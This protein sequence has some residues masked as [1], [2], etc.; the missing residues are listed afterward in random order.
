MPEP[1][2][3]LIRF[4][5]FSSR[6][7]SQLRMTSLI[8]NDPRTTAYSA[9]WDCP[10][11]FIHTHNSREAEQGS[12]LYNDVVARNREAVWLYMPR[13]EGEYISHIWKRSRS[14]CR[15]LALLVVTNKGR[16]MMFGPQPHPSWRPCNWT[17]LHRS[18]GS[19][20]RIF[21]DVSPHGI[22]KLA[23]DSPEPISHGQS[24]IIPTPLSPYPESTS[25][26]DYFYTFAALENVVE[27]TPCEGK[28]AG[29]R[30]I[31]GLLFRYADGHQACVGQFRLD[32]AA[33]PL[34]V[35]TSPKLWLSFDKKDGCPFV[36]GVG[37]SRPPKPESQ[38]CLHVSWDGKLEWW[39]SYRQC[40]L[41]YKGQSSVPTRP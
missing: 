8:C 18:D 21:F 2:P 36:D 5:S 9:C 6:S 23:F 37:V 7:P 12:A 3:N 28:V 13:D 1:R 34:V 22:H 38:E 17:L 16:L 15:E 32:C 11:L 27:I 25:L 20:S 26:E 41:Y 10:I 19:S 33:T 35:G 24:P 39:F 30:S 14:L 40:K 31:T 4:H 29:K